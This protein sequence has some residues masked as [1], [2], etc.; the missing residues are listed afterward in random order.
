MLNWFQIARIGRALSAAESIQKHSF[1]ITTG[2]ENGQNVDA[3]VVVSVDNAPWLF[4]QFSIE[5]HVY[6]TEFRHSPPAFRKTLKRV[7]AVLNLVEYSNGTGHA[8]CG[9]VGDYFVEISLSD[10]RPQNTVLSHFAS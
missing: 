5:K 1:Q 6:S 7:C 8:I 2:I 4:D 9:D 3:F 10:I